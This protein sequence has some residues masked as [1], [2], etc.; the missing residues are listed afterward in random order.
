MDCH[1]LPRGLPLGFLCSALTAAEKKEIF[2]AV[3]AEQS[4][5]RIARLEVRQ[6]REK[7]K[8]QQAGGR[9]DG[10]E[11]CGI[12][13][14]DDANKMRDEAGGRKQGERREQEGREGGFGH[15]AN[16]AKR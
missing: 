12:R 15:Q 9:T 3:L 10:D 2:K 4:S 13:D 7:D 1:G 11:A 14:Q 16:Q 8:E 6:E 5:R